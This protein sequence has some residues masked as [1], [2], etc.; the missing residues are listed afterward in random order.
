MN[1][2]SLMGP[3]FVFDLDLRSNR[4]D[5]CDAMPRSSISPAADDNPTGEVRLSS[6]LISIDQLHFT[7]AQGETHA[8]SLEVDH[9]EI[10]NSEHVACIGPSGTGKTTLIN[11]IAGILTPESGRITF[12]CTTIS[13]LD[14]ARRRALRISSIGLVFQE[15]ELLEYVTAFDN[16]LLPYFISDT[17]RLTPD[18]R[19]RAARLAE[20]MR[21]S[22]VLHRRP[23]RLSQGE[24]QRVAICRSMITEPKLIIADEPTGNLDP[25]TA[26]VTLD[27]LFNEIKKRNAALLMVTHNHSVLD[28]FQRIIDMTGLN[29]TYSTPTSNN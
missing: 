20:S 27:L 28:R 4:S 6:P 23:K 13:N 21:I 24:R 2:L 17:L 10:G 14:D 22:H 12:G 29:S 3:V 11:L 8:F 19:A 5:N 7:Y 1:V 9:L 25:E 18:I 15:F 16:I 26:D